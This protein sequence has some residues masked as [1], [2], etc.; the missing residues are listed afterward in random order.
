MPCSWSPCSSLVST[1]QS[2]EWSAEDVNW[3][4]SPSAQI[5]P[6][7]PHGTQEKLLPW[8]WP[9]TFPS[10]HHTLCPGLI[11]LQPHWLLSAPLRFHL[12]A[13]PLPLPLPLPGAL[14]WSSHGSC[15]LPSLYSGLHGNGTS[16][17]RSPDALTWHLYLPPSLSSALV[18]LLALITV[19]VVCMR[20][21]LFLFHF[22]GIISVDTQI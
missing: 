10:S 16:L 20:K 4:V 9:C 15:L 11:V 12:T 22:R 6:M 13:G 5:P 2:Q 14:S 3:V 19:D 18:F 17:E 7:A 1:N 8:P 21:S